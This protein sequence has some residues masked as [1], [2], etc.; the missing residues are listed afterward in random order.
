MCNLFFT[1]VKKKIVEPLGLNLEE[2]GGGKPTMVKNL[3]GLDWMD[4]ILPNPLITKRTLNH[5][6]F[7]FLLH[8]LIWAFFF[9]EK[10][11]VKMSRNPSNS[12]ISR[13]TRI[14]S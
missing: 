2:G 7:I 8:T 13:K 5:A 11:E 12:I 3:S 1:K 4:R 10:K 14:K 6:Y 9:F